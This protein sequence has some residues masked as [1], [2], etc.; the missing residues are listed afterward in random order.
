MNGIGKA[1]EGGSILIPIL[2]RLKE[3]VCRIWVGGWFGQ[4]FL[5]W[6]PWEK[7]SL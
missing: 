6:Y 4:S 5:Q 2:G 3:Q 1:I 7:A